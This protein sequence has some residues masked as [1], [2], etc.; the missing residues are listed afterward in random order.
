MTMTESTHNLKAQARKARE[1]R[2][3]AERRKAKLNLALSNV[4]KTADGKLVLMHI[5]SKA[6]VWS[7][8]YAGDNAALTAFREGERNLGLSI[9]ADMNEAEPD[10]F[11]NYLGETLNRSR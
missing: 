9:M 7:P 4:M 5:L 8:S 10:I 3:E 1:E 6:H 2:L 11:K